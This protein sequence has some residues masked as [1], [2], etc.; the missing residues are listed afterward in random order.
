MT[1]DLSIVDAIIAERSLLKHPFYVAWQKGELK[2]EDLRHYAK[3]YYPHVAAF[4]RY[5]SATHSRTEDLKA[6]QMLLENLIEEERGESNH[7]EL[8]LRFA[9][10]LGEDRDAVKSAEAPAATRQCVETFEGLT[11]ESD[12]AGLAALYAYE[13]Q[14]P[15]VSATKI[16]GL[17]DFYGIQAPEALEFFKVHE[18]AD[19]WHSQQER[20]LLGKAMTTEAGREVALRSTKKACDAVW[21]LLD[22]VCEARGIVCHAN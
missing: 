12:V 19:V 3:A 5:V 20:E 15:G 9:A 17:K 7:P 10:A 2:L 22:G 21:A 14:I 18:Q 11:R 8:W 13:S 4:P 1:S 16:Q 6:R